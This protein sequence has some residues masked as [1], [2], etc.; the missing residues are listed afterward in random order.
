MSILHGKLD[1]DKYNKRIIKPGVVLEYVCV[2]QGWMW[3]WLGV[4]KKDLTQK[5]TTE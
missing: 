4:F 1:C 5:V 3:F 2:W